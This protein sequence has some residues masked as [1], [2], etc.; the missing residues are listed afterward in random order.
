[1]GSRIGLHPVWLLFALFVFSYLFGFVGVLVAVP[2]A[3][4]TAVLIRHA[5]QVYLASNVYRGQK[6]AKSDGARQ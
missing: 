4:A 6:I 5:L 3:A 1:M 2:L